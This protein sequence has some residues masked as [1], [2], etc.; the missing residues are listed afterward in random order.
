MG[1]VSIIIVSFNGLHE[2]TA[3]CLRNIFEKT[4]F[5]EF[6]VIVVGNHST[7]GTPEFLAGL[8]GR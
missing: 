4:A 3:P 7:D 6:E 8:A 2:T 1:K 5:P